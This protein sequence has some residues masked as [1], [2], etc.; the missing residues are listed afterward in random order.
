[1]RGQVIELFDAIG[2]TFDDLLVTYSGNP[3]TENLVLLNGAFIN[4]GRTDISPSMVEQPI[5]VSLPEGYCWLLGKVVA[6]NAE[7][8]LEIVNDQSFEIRTGLFRCGE[9][10]KFHALARLPDVNSDLSNSKELMK[11]ITFSHRITNTKEVK[12]MELDD[13]KKSSANL[14]RRI[15][16][17]SIFLAVTIGMIVFVIYTGLPKRLSYNYAVSVSKTEAVVVQIQADDTV[18]IE[19]T[20]SEFEDEISFDEFV[21]KI[22]GSPMISE[23]DELFFLFSLLFALQILVISL[24]VGIATYDY[25][26][27]KRLLKLIEST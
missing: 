14:K 15:W 11:N 6:S 4:S 18:H 16:P 22:S 24:P 17:F 7:A 20:E 1:M 21:T 23:S 3:V 8:N 25:A 13:P 26:R 10:V 5:T 27:N 9:F 19:S 2:S 12:S